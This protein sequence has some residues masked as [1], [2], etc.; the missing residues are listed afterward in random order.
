M[1]MILTQHSNIYKH[2]VTYKY[3]FTYIYIY[4]YT[5]THISD[6][7]ISII[8]IYIHTHTHIYIYTRMYSHNFAACVSPFSPAHHFPGKG[9][10]V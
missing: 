4:K 8:Y 5:G 10:M 2:I 1:P 7:H 9:A 3:T 6:T